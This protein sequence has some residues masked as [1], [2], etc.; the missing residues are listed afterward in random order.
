MRNRRAR[1]YKPRR[2][3]LSILFIL[4][5]IY[6]SWY[7][8][9]PDL[10]ART[11]QTPSVQS[12]SD[13]DP[14]G[15]IPPELPSPDFVA[16]A[17]LLKVHFL[18]VGQA[19]SIVIQTPEGQTLL[20]DGG[21]KNDSDFIKDYLQELGVKELETVI[22]TH[23]HED[24]IGGLQSIMESFPVRNFYMPQVIH[25]TKTFEDMLT[26]VEKSGAKKIVARVG[27]NISTS[28]EYLS[29]IFLAPNSN[30]YE[31]LNNYS[32]VL[33]VSYKDISF[34]LTGD[35]EEFSEKEMLDN[36]RSVRATVLKVGHHGSRTSSSLD[37]LRAVKPAYAV[38][39]CGKD[40]V[41]GYPHPKSI[42]NLNNLNIGILRT[43]ILGTL[44]L[45]TDGDKLGIHIG[46]KQ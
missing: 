23:P 27:R 15:Y 32:A 28:E 14:E 33:K 21:N 19:D 17:R 42:E 2:L 9:T 3:I 22:A 4:A 24:H 1:T 20:V 13:Y 5:L 12:S 41:Y 46:D 25:T 10:E 36:N 26:S 38:I 44:V 45:E 31:E 39:S 43:D 7:L 34:L 18:D 40:N 30:K 8:L 35:A 6:N 16:G 37:F 29:M 11:A